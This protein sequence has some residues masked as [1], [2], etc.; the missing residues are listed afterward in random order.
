[1]YPMWFGMEMFEGG[2]SISD[3]DREIVRTLAKKYV[4][5]VKEEK[6]DSRVEMWQNHNDLK[7]QRPMILCFPEGSWREINLLSQ[8]TCEGELAKSIEH[9]LI[10]NT[11][12]VKILKDDNV[13]EAYFECPLIRTMSDWGIEQ[14]HTQPAERLGAYHIDPVIKSEEDIEKIT[15]PRITHHKEKSAEALAFLT[16]LL[17]DI[18]PIKQIGMTRN[19]IAPFDLYAQWRGIDQMFMDLIDN[20]EFA[21][22]LVNIIIDSYITM[23]KDYENEDVLTVGNRSEMSGSGGNCFTR[24]LPL[25]DFDGTNVRLKD[26]WGFCTNQIFSEVSP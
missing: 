26:Q 3:S 4:E 7:R 21:H 20:T 24:Q 9:S 13:Y 8:I 10:R 1:M 23:A 5:A 6:A 19:C 22:K 2:L 12:G 15:S 16:D 18:M 14:K 17:G 25:D 11:Y